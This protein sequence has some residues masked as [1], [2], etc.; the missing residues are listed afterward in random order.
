V[1][2]VYA[3]SVLP[4]LTSDAFALLWAP[5]GVAV[6]TAIVKI[7]SKDIRSEAFEILDIAVGFDLY[8]AATASLVMFI[9]S[10][11]SKYNALPE[12]F[13][14]AVQNDDAKH[15]MLSM[16]SAAL[17]AFVMALFLIPAGYLHSRFGW[18]RHAL[19][20]GGSVSLPTMPAIILALVI[21]GAAFVITGMLI[22]R[23]T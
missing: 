5:L 1:I 18:K 3:P 6:L 15:L 2:D 17:I 11:V 13:E 12:V 22:G 10:L 23:L 8:V 9:I 14:G 16:A 7:A 19:V 4:F 20:S 21:G